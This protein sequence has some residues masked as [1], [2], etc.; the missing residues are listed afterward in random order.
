MDEN[1][2]EVKFAT[3]EKPHY[4]GKDER[5]RGSFQARLVNLGTEIP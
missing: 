5:L 3:G 2:N 1:K 4:C